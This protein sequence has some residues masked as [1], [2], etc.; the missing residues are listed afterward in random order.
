VPERVAGSDLIWTVSEA[1][2]RRGLS[3]FLLGGNPGAAE[4]AG[5][6]LVERYPGLRLAGTHFPP[7]GFDRDPDAMREVERAVAAARP[8]IV[9][10]GLPFPLQAVVAEHLAERLP[11]SWFLCV[12]VSF[13]FVTGE[14]RRA[15]RWIRRVGAEWLWRLSQ[16]PRRLA[17]RY[18][19]HGIPFAFRL[20]GWA[21]GRR[22]A[23]PPPSRK[24]YVSVPRGHGAG[25]PDQD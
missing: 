12:G 25:T 14:I 7:F 4:D 15:P 21:L 2:A 13:S 9:F 1:A 11:R 3:V 23:S 19:V 22:L 18:L 20:F 24:P 17:D 6:R 8:D 10:V 16:E 5:R